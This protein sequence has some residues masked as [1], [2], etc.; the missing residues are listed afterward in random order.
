MYVASETKLLD[1]LQTRLPRLR[2]RGLE[3]FWFI[4]KNPALRLRFGGAALD[5]ECAREVEALLDQLHTE[6]VVERWFPSVY[7]PESFSLG[8][9]ACL[10][11]V[12]R[13]FDH[14]SAA[15]MAWRLADAQE[16]WRVGPDVL[17][18]AAMGDL[19]Y[20]CLYPN[21][22]EIW[23]V[24]CNVARTYGR[25]KASADI[26]AIQLDQ[27]ERLAG[28]RSASIVAQYRHANEELAQGLE[29]L[30]Q[31]GQLNVGRRA[32]L[33][34]IASFH[35]NRYVVRA[36]VIAKFADA[37]VRC[38]DPRAHL[39]G[40]GVRVHDGSTHEEQRCD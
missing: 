14:D 30:W 21:G 36:H 20:R 29:R 6:N 7:E 17:S 31:S 27:L 24:W 16:P 19:F 13:Y 4:R 12:H 33:P 37:M 2:A 32:L 40:A 5:P 15:C 11:L 23:D 1:A 28:P 3:S 39:V 18:L 22:E 35:W 25:P 9:D 10:E 8:G 34:V 38:L 26:P